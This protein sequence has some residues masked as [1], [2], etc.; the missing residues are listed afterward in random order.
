MKLNWQVI[1]V[2]FRRNLV[3]YFASPTGY[4]FITLFIFLSAAAAFWQER[5]FADNLANLD[6]LNRLFP[7]LL[8][9]FVPAL[10]MGSW[11]D[12][13]KQGTDELLLTLPATDLE[14]V[15]GKYFAV[16]GIYTA[17]L[18]LS[19][20]HVIVLYWLGNPDIG[21][22]F[23][24]YVGYW[25][26]GAAL[27]SVGMF[28]SLLTA[29]VTVAFILGALMSSV[30]VFADSARLIV[31]DWLYRGV[32]L[33]GI[34]DNFADLGSGIVSLASVLYFVSVTAVMIYLNVLL[35]GRRH[36]PQ[37]AG[38]RKFWIHQAVRMVAVVV[39]VVSFNSLV[40]QASI[41][42][43]VTAEHLHS[44][45]D[46]TRRLI[47][48]LPDDRPVLVEAF[49]SSEV[50]RQYV[51]T[52]AN[53][54]S[55]LREVSA[56][57]G[58]KV[59]VLFH[60]TEPFS[61]EA[62]DAREKFGIVPRTIVGS[63][64]GQSKT[65]DLFLGVAFTSGVNQVVIP[66]FDRGLPV[67]YEIVRSVRV[68]ANSERLRVGV[69]QSEAKLFGDFDFETMA[70]QPPWPVVS[71]LR[72]QYEVVQVSAEEPI[73]LELDA[74]LAVLPSSLTQTELDNLK[75]YVLAGHPTML[76]V[77]PLPAFDISLS[78]VLPLNT[79][80][81][82]FSPDAQENKQK[83]RITDLMDAIG[84]HWSPG[85]VVWDQYNPHPDLSQL[86]QEIVFI[87]EGSSPSDA[88]DPL[89]PATAGL[90]ELVTIFGGY[91]FKALNSEFTF[92]PL[93][94]TGTISGLVPWNELVRRSLFGYQLNPSVR[95]V[96][97]PESYI[98]AAHVTGIPKP[99]P[100]DSAGFQETTESIDV[101]IMADVDFVGQQFFQ[102]REQGIEGLEF[103]NIT[104]FLNCIDMLAGDS[105]FIEL[106][107]KRLRHRTLTA[108]EEQTQL[109]MQQRIEEERQA[110][111]DA[112]GALKQAQQRLNERV[113]EVRE[114]TDLDDQTKQI[115]AQNLQTIENRRLEA[116]TENINARKEATVQA[117]REKV[118]R[119][120]RSIQSRIKTLAVVLPPIPV[121]FV[122]AMIFV[123]RR[124][125]EIEGSRVARR[126]RS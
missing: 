61:E 88:F 6:Q 27:L 122:G 81:N 41:R 113:N 5:F 40:S 1:Y 30:F 36:W 42:L 46:T 38:G 26:L 79:R 90:Q 45:S 53:L 43:D 58:D 25:L 91:V 114:R 35:V 97:S 124:R 60:D 31:S 21:L 19:L 64:G 14:I 101:V 102:M 47:D 123:R 37:E 116:L 29:N 56:A 62:R 24:N 89:T 108:V 120:I 39:A 119:S 3:S 98:L 4:V 49:L 17:S 103:D 44:L 82:P 76:L 72:K 9:F 95:R 86:P 93:L 55:I 112:E 105:S 69:L 118:E 67:E 22:M 100:E 84:V 87:H 63:V 99:R 2:L 121:L 80:G 70:N 107:K 65:F 28:A 23:A 13:R 77:D 106:R 78:P 57:A 68:A 125:R 59:Q 96:P 51:E 34:H 33:L 92:Q 18:L 75:A 71:E 110:E 117:S 54:V 32:S 52:R 94:R 50:P 111:T 126:L 85:M 12:E 74:L 16:V 115:M 66:F 7:Y 109:F 11:A 15:L 104:F 10:T 83:G 20:S 8:L 48:Q 73:D